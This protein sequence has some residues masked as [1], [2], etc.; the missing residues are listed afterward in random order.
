[1]C[2]PS[3]KPTASRVKFLHSVVYPASASF[4]NK[5]VLSNVSCNLVFSCEVVITKPPA[6]K[7]WEKKNSRQEH[8]SPGPYFDTELC[9]FG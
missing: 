3:P 6:F 1:M 7:I 2:R 4:P 9:D 8:G 5:M